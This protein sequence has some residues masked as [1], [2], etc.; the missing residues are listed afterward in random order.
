MWTKLIASDN[1]WVA[2]DNAE[3]LKTAATILVLACSL[4]IGV[5]GLVIGLLQA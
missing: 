2:A 4:A 3:R 5:V 1:P